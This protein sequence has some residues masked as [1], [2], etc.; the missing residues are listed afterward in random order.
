MTPTRRAPESPEP[1]PDRIFGPL[2]GAAL[3]LIWHDG[4]MSVGTAA[5]RL[6]TQLGRPLA[7]TTVMTI[8][9]RLHEKGL[10]TRHKVGRQYVYGAAMSEAEAS[11]ASSRLAIEKVLD[12][13][14]AL[15]LRQFAERLSELD[16]QLRTQLMEL[17][18]THREPKS[19]G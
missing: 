7:Y 17:A 2:T 8:L 5:E 14:G 11:A 19:G 12:R 16:P 1:D 15:A 3:R 18:S 13:Y 6:R 4:D 9:T 10:L